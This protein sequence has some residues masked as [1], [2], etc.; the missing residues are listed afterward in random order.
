MNQWDGKLW[1]WVN[2]GQN[3]RNREDGRPKGRARPKP[4]VQPATGTHSAENY[5]LNQGLMGQI[6]DQEPSDRSVETC[7]EGDV[8]YSGN[9]DDEEN[10]RSDW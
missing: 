3:R 10:R 6:Q 7:Q 8:D 1:T 5:E 9:N 2:S 4:Q